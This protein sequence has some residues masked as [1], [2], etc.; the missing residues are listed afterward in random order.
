[1]MKNSLRKI[2]LGL[3]N[4]VLTCSFL[5]VGFLCFAEEQVWITTYYPSPVG[6]YRELRAHYMTIGQNYANVTQY[7]WIPP[8]MTL[9]DWLTS[10]IIQGRV[11]IGT[12]NP[13]APLEIVWSP[14]SPPAYRFFGTMYGTWSEVIRL[15]TT[16]PMP[17]E[18]SNASITFRQANGLMGFQTNPGAGTGLRGFY[19][20]DE[21]PGNEHNEL[22]VDMDN[23]LTNVNSLNVTK[24][25]I[26]V[27]G[28]LT[29][30]FQINGTVNTCVMVDYDDQGDTLCPAGFKLVIPAQIADDAF[31][32]ASYA[33]PYSW[34]TTGIMTCCRVCPTAVSSSGDGSCGS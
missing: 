10:F 5:V 18:S 30:S 16:L 19:V 32:E 26:N 8:C 6:V 21:T 3:L 4:F 12:H 23:D 13:S 33:A 25:G 29:S 9:L 27:Q 14:F 7:G 24:L 17:G 15:N 22:W 20:V 1:M 31:S 34:L 11:G 28:P 2:R